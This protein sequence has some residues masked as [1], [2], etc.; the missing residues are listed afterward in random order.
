MILAERSG[1]ALAMLDGILGE[2]PH[3]DVPW[4]VAYLRARLAEHSLAGYR[5]WEARSGRSQRGCGDPSLQQLSDGVPECVCGP[6]RFP[7]RQPARRD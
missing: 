3:F 6:G 2:D 7:F 1:H 5:A 4:S